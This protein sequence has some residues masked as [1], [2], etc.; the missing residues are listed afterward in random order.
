M[1]FLSRTAKIKAQSRVK[2]FEMQDNNLLTY[3]REGMKV[4]DVEGNEIGTVEEVYFGSG[5][6]TADLPET[7]DNDILDIIKSAFGGDYNIPDEIKERLIRKGYVRI[8]GMGL[9][10]RDR[11]VMPEQI[12]H[13]SDEGVRL[14][15]DDDQL[16][17]EE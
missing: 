5:G 6:V 9:L 3:V 17:H 13:V 8:D 11:F 16:L 15:T 4:Y 12:A 14:R 7:Y 1:L 10:D 2:G